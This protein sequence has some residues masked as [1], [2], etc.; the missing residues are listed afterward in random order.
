MTEELGFL[1]VLSAQIVS[2][3]LILVFRAR[4]GLDTGKTSHKK[5]MG[6]LGREVLCLHPRVESRYMQLHYIC[7][8]GCSSNMK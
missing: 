5:F 3:Q 8:P 6:I 4:I 7:S 2:S 1:E